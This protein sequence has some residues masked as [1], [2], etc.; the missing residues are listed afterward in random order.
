MPKRWPVYAFVAVVM[1]LAATVW[2]L[3][4][5]GSG[6]LIP[7]APATWT[8][9][10]PSQATPVPAPFHQPAPT[11]LPLEPFPENVVMIVAHG[12]YG[13]GGG[14][15]YSVTRHYRDKNGQLLTDEV[16][17]QAEN[18]SLNLTG[19]VA[20]ERGELFVSA[21]LME[22]CGFEG[23]SKP[24]VET[25]FSR[26][27]DG[28]ITWHEIDRKAGKWWARLALDDS[29]VAVNFEGQASA[30]MEFPGAKAVTPPA[31]AIPVGLDPIAFRGQLAW[32]AGRQILNRNGERVYEFELPGY[33]NLTVQSVLALR[34]GGPS[35]TMD[36]FPVVVASWTADGLPGQQQFFI[37][38]FLPPIGL[39][40]KVLKIENGTPR[41]AGWINER[42]LI[43]TA[44][45]LRPSTCTSDK[46]SSGADPAIIPY[47]LGSLSFIGTPFYS[48]DC[49]LGSQRVV[50]TQFIAIWTRIKGDGDCVNLRSAPSI[51]AQVLD[52]L[53]DGAI[54]NTGK[55]RSNDGTRFWQSVTGPSGQQGWIADEFLED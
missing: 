25:I 17:K 6:R 14:G 23:P 50:S 10:P 45:Y 1:V 39:P 26:S 33:P 19:I 21:C 12:G 53:G 8:P 43:V 37:G 24:G 11:V 22:L 47:D 32:I 20:N 38:T 27:T 49:S 48:A 5:N 16:W 44:D 54:V 46:V 31:S 3:R 13:H 55:A 41:L 40:L 36:S 34:R 9:M 51:T 4:A 15:Y 28:G 52:C 30:Y 42:D 7:A 35:P 2:V 18:G 29:V